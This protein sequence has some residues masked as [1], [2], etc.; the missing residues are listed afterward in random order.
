MEKL[1]TPDWWY[2]FQELEKEAIKSSANLGYS[3]NLDKFFKSALHAHKRF[4]ADTMDY[5]INRGIT[6]SFEKS[7]KGDGLLRSDFKD[8]FWIIIKEGLKSFERDCTLFHE[9]I[10]ACFLS[11]NRFLPFGE[12][13][14][15]ELEA[16]VE[17][18]ARKLRANPEL[19]RYTI[20]SF[21]LTPEVYD[22]A[23]YKAFPHHPQLSSIYEQI[24]TRMD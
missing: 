11:T 9:L 10:H 24:G 3:S 8:K 17:F 6:I 15:F 13:E 1:K 22:L 2:N 14:Y 21:R 16:I 7:L 4:N 5:L 19:L 23:S 18:N 20:N 12:K